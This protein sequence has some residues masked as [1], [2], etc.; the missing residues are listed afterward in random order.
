M[1]SVDPADDARATDKVFAAF[2]ATR[3]R[4][5]LRE[6]LAY[7][8]KVTQFRFVAVVRFEAGRLVAIGYHDRQDP[9]L[10]SPVR[11]PAVVTA[12]CYWRDGNGALTTVG[13]A[14]FTLRSA[15]DDETCACRSVPVMDPE[16]R[17]QATLCLY[18]H[19]ARDPDRI[20]LSLLLSGCRLSGAR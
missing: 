16:G 15:Q 5:G 2:C 4:T 19:S 20:D 13:E 9:E 1:C 7:L 8:G 14:G 17:V 18:D 10:V 3:A 12:S 6:A 11:W